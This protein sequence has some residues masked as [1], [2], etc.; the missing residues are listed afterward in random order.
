MRAINLSHYKTR[1]RDVSRE[2]FRQHGWEMPRGLRDWRERDPLSYSLEEWR[3]ARRV[4]LDPKQL[5]AMFQEC[6][7]RSDSGMAF[8]QALKER[9]FMLARGDRRGFVAVDYRGEVYAVARQ[10]GVK[11]KDVVAR[12]GEPEAFPSAE[13]ARFGIAARM[14]ERI[15]RFIKQTELEAGRGARRSNSS[16]ASWPDGIGTSGKRS[17]KVTRS[18][19][20]QRPTRGRRDCRAASRASGT[21]SQE[22]TRKS[23]IETSAKP[24]K[25]CCGI[26]RS[27]TT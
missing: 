27:G 8:A 12:L 14:S 7:N 23:G 6:W 4:G 18:A 5:K 21:G 22:N 24:G 1:L 17:R 26:A 13:E 20:S 10:A 15:K 11:S 3:Q 16:G 19:G 9:G 2:L 25:P